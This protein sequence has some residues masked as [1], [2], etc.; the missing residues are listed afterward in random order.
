MARLN[1]GNIWI[2]AEGGVLWRGRLD[3][4]DGFILGAFHETDDQNIADN[5]E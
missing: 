2:P 4:V 3:A 5:L 1:I